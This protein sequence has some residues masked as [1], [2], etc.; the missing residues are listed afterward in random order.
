MDITTIILIFYVLPVVILT[1]FVFLDKG[2]K[3]IGDVLECLKYILVPV[4]NIV[5][6]FVIPAMFLWHK[7]NVG[8]W[9]KDFK[10]KKFRD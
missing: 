4:V 2:N 5:F 9:W 3:T 1:V 10:N 6:V 8:E 7:F